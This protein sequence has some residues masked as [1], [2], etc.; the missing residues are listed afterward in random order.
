MKLLPAPDVPGSTEFERLGNFFLAVMVAPKATVDK[1]N[2]KCKRARA[3][4]KRA[5]Q[6]AS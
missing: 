3:K 4:K 6:Y 2:A 5:S 1:E